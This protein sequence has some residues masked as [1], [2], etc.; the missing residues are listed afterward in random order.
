[1]TAYMDNGQMIVLLDVSLINYVGNPKFILVHNEDDY[2]YYF[3]I[4]LT[5]ALERN[6]YSSA[7]INTAEN[8]F[9]HG[10]CYIN[11]TAEN[12]DGY[13]IVMTDEDGEI[14]YEKINRNDGSGPLDDP[15]ISPSLNEGKNYTDLIFVDLPAGYYNIT[16]NSLG[17]LWIIGSSVSK[18]IRILP[19][20]STIDVDV[21]S[22]AVYGNP[23][24]VGISGENLTT[25]NVTVYDSNGNI[26]FSQNTTESVIV[27][28]VL[29]AGMYN[30]TAFNYGNV[31]ISGSMDSKMVNILKASN[32]ALVSVG[33]VVYGV[34][35]FVVVTADVDG[36]YTLNINGTLETVD[37]VDGVGNVSVSLKPGFYWANATFNNP[38]YE[39]A[40]INDTF[41]VLKAGT[42]I[43]V[44]YDAESNE[45][46][47]VLTNNATGQTIKGYT[48]KVKLH[49]ETYKLV[50]DVNGQVRVSAADLTPGTI[51]TVGVTFNGGT[52]YNASKVTAKVPIVADTTVSV[53]Y[54]AETKDMVATLIN[55][56]TGQ[57]IK[58][59]TLHVKLH[60][61]TYK[62]VTDANGQVR[63]S[64][65]DL[66]P[67][68]IYTVSVT[69]KGGTKYNA[70]KITAKIPI[71]ANTSVE[72]G[73]DEDDGRIFA[74][75]INSDTDD[76][77]KGF[78]LRVTINN[79]YYKLVTDEYGL[80]SVSVA[81]LAPGD[82]TVTVVFLGGTKYNPSQTSETI[83][84]ESLI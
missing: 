10:D 84:I 54:D 5:L 35:A 45:M 51:Y 59:F 79:E 26:V 83:Y 69:F 66:D 15:L 67:G 21:E 55:N 65:A 81:H 37:V 80:V 43:T 3:G 52:K 11:F 18:M 68:T 13:Y 19:L 58:G 77:I 12:C 61:E 2:Y 63:I 42:N 56:A 62:L 4:N 17:S 31:N 9:I 57:A 46:V 75:L 20:N 72:V 8:E 73:Y 33:D 71:V 41:T 60:G 23:I 40:I 38:N 32:N 78:T 34:G 76:A 44:F 49:G 39:S 64:A 24:S 36:D 53:F 29:P 30:V 28:P 1:Y 48:L 16:V 27:L 82:Y 22:E 25:V 6:I 70:A 14:V 74:G 50:T 47:A 7:R